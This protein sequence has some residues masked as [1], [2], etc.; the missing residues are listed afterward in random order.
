MPSAHAGGHELGR[1]YLI[2]PAVID[3]IVELTA[4]T[5]G[6]IVEIGCGTGALTLPLETLGRSI[7]AVDVDPRSVDRLRRRCGPDTTVV[8]GDILGYRWPVEPHV[9]VGNLPFHLTTAILR[10]LFPVD[11]WSAAILIL[12]WEVARRRAA[13][14]GATLMTAQW[15]PWFEFELIRRV[16]ATAF[17]PRPG[18]DAG[19]LV[20][21]RRDHPL[22]DRAH[23][24]RYASFT[25]RVFTGRGSGVPDILDR[26]TPT[27]RRPAVRQL[28]RDLRLN[29]RTMPRDL[30]PQQ[31]A[32]LFRLVAVENDRPP[33]RP[34]SRT[35]RGGRVREAE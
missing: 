25:H 12:Q 8:A 28:V 13:V 4:H 18:V 23:G 26:M 2:D 29:G 9:V 3:H 10:T 20:I 6:P 7:T 31:W 22:L 5:T 33:R 21:R 1:N 19:V 17:R 24:R 16:P 30:S 35:R 32:R 14:G 15:W 11:G 34:H 27:H